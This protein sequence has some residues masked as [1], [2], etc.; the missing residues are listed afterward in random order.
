MI[1]SCIMAVSYLKKT[2]VYKT[3]KV[4]NY[5]SIYVQLMRLMKAKQL[6]M[7]AIAGADP[8]IFYWGSGSKLWFRKDC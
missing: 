6:P 2:K 8:G 1:I 5:F 3:I 4:T 7:A